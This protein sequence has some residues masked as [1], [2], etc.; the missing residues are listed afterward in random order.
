MAEAYS[1]HW[2]H[3]IRHGK[4]LLSVPVLFSCPG[5]TLPIEFGRFVFTL[6]LTRMISA[7][8]D[9]KVLIDMEPQRSWETK[10][11]FLYRIWLWKWNKT[12]HLQQQSS[13]WMK[14]LSGLSQVTWWKNHTCWGP[15]PL[16]PLIMPELLPITM[17]EPE[18]TPV[19][20]EAV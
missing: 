9:Q 20:K 11:L 2:G 1:L 14:V 10:I 5:P 4:L 13:M 3:A 17:S 16:C 6:K 8:C 18:S 7:A 12:K 19:I 15:P